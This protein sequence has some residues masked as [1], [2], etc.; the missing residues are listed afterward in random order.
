MNTLKNPL[1]FSLWETLA[2]GLFCEISRCRCGVYAVRIEKTTLQLTAMQFD[3]IA[4][5]FKLVCGISSAMP[6]CDETA[7]SHP[8][9]LLFPGEGFLRKKTA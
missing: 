5:A 9:H 2:S 4:R 3:Q 6:V 8:D 7:H 1:G